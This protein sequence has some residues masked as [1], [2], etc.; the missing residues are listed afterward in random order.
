MLLIQRFML[1]RLVAYALVATG[2]VAIVLMLVATADL[3]FM[4]AQGALSIGRF[5]L[6]LST[7]VPMV[8]AQGTPIGATAGIGFA[9]YQWHHN[10]EILPLRSAGFT[11]MALA[12]PGMIAAIVAM[13]FTASMSLYLLPVAFRT[14]EDIR[15]GAILNLTINALD[16]G[17][18]QAV[19]GELSLA[20]RKR[21][22][23]NELEGVTVL[24]G[25]KP[26]TFISIYAE[27]GHLVIRRQ[28]TPEE[29][30]VLEDGTYYKRTKSDE[31]PDSIAFGQLIVPISAVGD[32]S[33]TRLW[34][35]FYEEH[36]PRL[37]NPPPEIRSTPAMAA[38]WIAEG[39]HRIIYPILCLSYVMFALGAILR[40]RYQRHSREIV[41][42]VALGLVILGWDAL[43]GVGHSF[44]V[45]APELFPAYYLLAVMPLVAGIVLLLSSERYGRRK[46]IAAEA[47]PSALE[48]ETN[49]ALQ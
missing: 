29:V 28:P 17:Y 27:R 26:G 48:V 32:R 40:S 20:F 22:A 6:A 11:T 9:Y 37:I 23:E 2:T 14:F 31:R 46:R 38:E 35:G 41:R 19:S 12:V 30:L 15:Y 8:F 3:F 21:V 34:R 44:V 16:E 47:W 18:L 7:I 1:Y 43:M 42:F 45:H 39:H 25:R 10:T 13:I 36:V 4:L 5:F 24:D 49:T 33:A